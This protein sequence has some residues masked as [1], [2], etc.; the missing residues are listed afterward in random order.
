M[1]IIGNGHASRETICT[2]DTFGIDGM[3]RLLKRNVNDYNGYTEVERL[4]L[5]EINLQEERN[6]VDIRRLALLENIVQSHAFLSA[7]N[8]SQILEE[9]RAG[10]D[11]ASVSLL[12]DETSDEYVD[13][14]DIQQ[15]AMTQCVQQYNPGNFTELFAVYDSIATAIAAVK[16]KRSFL[17][18]AA[19]EKTIYLGFRWN[20]VE[21]EDKHKVMDIGT[22]AQA[23][24]KRI[25]GRVA[26]I[27]SDSKT[28]VDVFANRIKAGESVSRSGD[29][30]GLA[31]Q[32]KELKY[33]FYW[34]M[35][36]TCSDEL[37]STI[38][39]DVACKPN[40][41]KIVR[42]YH[43]ETHALINTHIC[44]SEVCRDFKMCHKTLKKVSKDNTVYNGFR[45]KICP[46]VITV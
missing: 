10:T 17:T 38:E 18:D 30:I 5:R 23:P 15:S 35:Y 19:A 21:K 39:T 12:S 32:S 25:H 27:S 46:V 22:T 45:W 7:T 8:V 41:G 1:D 43:P 44:M 34:M 6:D 2:D 3:V 11:M 20:L 36:D 42:Q 31:I 9:L 26:K 40:S 33:E 13:G 24:P 37:K 16:G 14:R 4:K 29:M 28:I